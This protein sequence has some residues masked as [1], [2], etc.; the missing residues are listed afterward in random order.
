MK[1]PIYIIKKSLFLLF[2]SVK[3]TLGPTGKIAIIDTKQKIELVD[4]GIKILK[5]LKFEKKIE[6]TILE[7]IR[8]GSLRTNQI[9]GDGTTTTTLLTCTFL[10]EGLKLLSFGINNI[11]LIVG[12]K[13]ILYFLIQKIKELSFPLTSSDH[14]KNILQTSMGNISFQIIDDLKNVFIKKGK[15]GI[16]IVEE[17]SDFLHQSKIE[18]FDGIQIEEGY[19]SPYFLKHF[20]QNFLMLENP[21]LLI[22]DRI[23][24]NIEQIRNI[25][26]FI[27]INK[28]SLIVIASGFEKTVLSTLIINNLN[29]NLNVVAIKAPFF[30]VK[31]KMILEDICFIT[32][33]NF[34]DEE[35]Y[36]S[37]YQFKIADLGKVKKGHIRKN[38][39]NLSLIHSSNFLL[40]K[41]IDELYRK[42]KINDSLYEQEIIKYRINL[43]SNSITKFY[44]SAI[45][46]S[47]LLKLKLK[48]ENGINS[49]KSSFQEGITIS[50]NSLYVHLKELT[51]NW[52]IINL[53]NNEFFAYKIFEKGLILPF[54]QISENKNL[55][56]PLILNKTLKMGYPFGYNFKTNEFC[57]LKENGILDSSKMI[58][59]ILQNSVSIIISLFSTF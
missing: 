49:L 44:L 48:I 56:F 28:H 54:C 4:D 39:T 1:L 12:I 21:Y 55:K 31:R 41:R 59:V 15:D 26:E 24:E 8:Q 22:T 16:L 7:L 42:S 33:T 23:I 45:T 29:D 36:F 3:S 17:K 46:D 57:N 34:I 6:N 43:L 19:C 53:T 40:K 37:N 5:S 10:E 20:S 50:C 13:K 52:S 51:L 35:I 25:L 14:I 27:K 30:S 2:N 32:N 38:M 9:V 47:E 18:T 11:Y 58:R